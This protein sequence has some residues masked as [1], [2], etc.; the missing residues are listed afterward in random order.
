MVLTGCLS[1]QIGTRIVFINI[2]F[3]QK[4]KGKSR[5]RVLFEFG[6]I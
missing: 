1:V 6:L 2:H 3:L 4:A 5:I